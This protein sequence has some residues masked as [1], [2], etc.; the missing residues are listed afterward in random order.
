[1][2]T[3]RRALVV[4]PYGI[5]DLLFVTPVLRALRL[6]PGIERVDM[7]LGSRTEKVIRSNPHVDDLFPIDKDRF[8]QRS[9]WKNLAEI[10]SLTRILQS[11]HY[12]LLLDYSQRPEYGFWAKFFLRIPVRSGFQYKRS[13]LFLTHKTS[14]AEG[15]TGKS[16]VHFFCE[17][18]E[19][20]GVRVEDRFL[21][22]YVT[23]QDRIEAETFLTQ[24]GLS[25]KDDYAVISPGGGESWG[26]DA[27]F[28]RWPADHFASLFNQVKLRIGVSQVLILGSAGE[29]TLAEQLCKKLEIKAVNLAGACSINVSAAILGKAQCFIGNDG[30]LVHMAHAFQIPVVA[31]YGPVDPGV[32]GPFPENPRAVSIFKEGLECR[33]CYQRFRY[34][35]ACI[36]RDCLQA[37]SVEEAVQMLDQ[38]KWFQTL[39][40]AR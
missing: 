16:V 2:K 10:F 12:D 21:E 13:G 38:K 29:K 17:A 25:L 27:H 20:A 7:I 6:L 37:L 19:K 39:E 23:D 26:R 40:T 30:G 4:A 33:P 11:R 31:F 32:Y 34:N 18:A 9:L 35:S 24:Y 14:T 28:K 22:F 36:H 5:G 8:H 15:F 1:M 3:I